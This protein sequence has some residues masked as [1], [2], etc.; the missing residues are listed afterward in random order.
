[1][2]LSR[3]ITLSVILGVSACTALVVIAILAP[4]L[5]PFSGAEVLGDV[6]EPPSEEFLLGTDNL[7]RDLLSRMIFGAQITIFMAAAATTLA[8]LA[9]STL[10]IVSA[11]LGGV[12]D[13]L[14]SRLV[15][16][17]MC[18]PP[19]IFALVILSVFP[20]TTPILVG[21]IGLLDSTRV[22]RIARALAGDIMVHD[23]VE[24]ARLRRDGTAW[25]LWREVLPNV[26]PPLVSELGLRFIYAVLILS[27]LSFLG[28][29]VQPPDADWGAM[30]RENKGGIVFGIPAAILP[31]S[32]ISVLAI[33][34]NLIV[35]WFLTGTERTFDIQK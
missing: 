35:D 28:L 16:I 18:I 21:V 2:F 17:I 25:I 22:Y 27:S 3:P 10:G 23:Y 34:V 33:A 20:A 12:F 5:A 8:F 1:M 9:G 15:D 6:W 4:L 26:L 32:A 30:V 11:I 31:A 29:G 7:G 19:L 13:N 24:V 14:V